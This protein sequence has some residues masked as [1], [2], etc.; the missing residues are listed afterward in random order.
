MNL[1]EDHGNFFKE[2]NKQE[3]NISACSEF[4]YGFAFK[5][6]V[7][8]LCWS[9]A[10]MILTNFLFYYLDSPKHSFIGPGK[11]KVVV[12]GSKWKVWDDC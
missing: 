4:I 5:L 2:E 8:T 10:Q 11:N 6:Y 9:G 12:L 7:W 1:H 3:E